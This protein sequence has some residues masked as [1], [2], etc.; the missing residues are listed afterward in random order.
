MLRQYGKTWE[1]YGK[2][3]LIFQFKVLAVSVYTIHF[4]VKLILRRLTHL[5]QVVIPIKQTQ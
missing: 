3:T 1:R 5:F 2:Q 4:K